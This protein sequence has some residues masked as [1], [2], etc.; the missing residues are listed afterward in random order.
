MR[1]PALALGFVVAGCAN[2]GADGEVHEDERDDGVEEE[3][4]VGWSGCPLG[5]QLPSVTA[6]E[7]GEDAEE[8]AGDFKPE[9]A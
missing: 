7:N 3:A 1:L 9:L 6:E 8:K 5:T 4:G 2:K